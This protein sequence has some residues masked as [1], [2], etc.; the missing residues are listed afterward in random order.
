MLEYVITFRN[1]LIIGFKQF[2]GSGRFGNY[3]NCFSFVYSV[4]SYEFNY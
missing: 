1:V 4:K 2:T 3:V